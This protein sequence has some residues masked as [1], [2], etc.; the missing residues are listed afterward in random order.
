MK[1]KKKFTVLILFLLLAITAGIQAQDTRWD[2]IPGLI[3]SEIRLNLPELTYIELANVDDVA[4][5][6]KDFKITTTENYVPIVPCGFAYLPDVVLQP[7][8]TFII[9]QVNDLGD[10][11]YSENLYLG[12][13][14]GWMMRTMPEILEYVDLP[15]FMSESNPRDPRDSVSGYPLI[16]RSDKPFLAIA[17]PGRGAF[18]EYFEGGDS[19]F[20]DIFFATALGDALTY[21]PQDG[22][23][24]ESLTAVAGVPRVVGAVYMGGS[25]QWP[26]AREYTLVRKTTVEHG[27]IIWDDERGTSPDNS[28]WIVV[29]AA[30]NQRLAMWEWSKYFTTI[31]RHGNGSISETTVT[32]DVVTIDWVNHK[33]SVPWGIRRFNLM[34]HI[35]VGDNITWDFIQNGN[36]AD[37]AH[38][39]VCTGDKL[40]MYATGEARQEVEFDLEIVAA[41]DQTKALVFQLLVPSQEEGYIAWNNIYEVTHDISGMDTIYGMD[42]G[43]RVDSLYKYLEKAE[44]ATWRLI[45]I[46]GLPDRADLKRG[47]LLRVTNGAVTKDYYLSVSSTPIVALDGYLQF[48]KW[49]D[50]PDAL[51]SSDAW[52]NNDI[53]PNFINVVKDYILDLPSG[54]KDVPA[55]TAIPQDVNATVSIVPA[56]TLNGLPSERTTRITVMSEDGLSTW[57]YTVRFDVANSSSNIQ[58]FAADPIFTRFIPALGINDNLA[59]IGNPGTT[60]IDLSNYVVANALGGETPD[61]VLKRAISNH[62]F[63]FFAYVPG[64]DYA[65]TEAEWLTKPGV[66]HPD[67][68]I[69]PI[70]PPGKCFVMADRADGWW[71]WFYLSGGTRSDMMM[72]PYIDVSFVNIYQKQQIELNPEYFHA[73]NTTFIRAGWDWYGAVSQVR[74]K[75]FQLLYKIVGD[76][77]KEGL[78]GVGSDLAD[79]QLIDMMGTYDNT[80]WEPITGMG[81]GLPV[82]G[83]DW[84]NWSYLPWTIERKP[85][86]WKGNPLPGGSWGTAETSEWTML[87]E[88]DIYGNEEV[89]GFWWAAWQ[90]ALGIDRHIFTPVTESSSTILSRLYKVSG[91]YTSPQTITGVITGTTVADFMANIIKKDAYQALEVLHKGIADA[92][93]SDDTLKVTSKDSKN[94]TNYILTVADVGLSDN[95]TLVAKTGS[96]LTVEVSG[97]DGA[98]SGVSFGI[99]LEELLSNLVKPANSTLR[100]IDESGN[101]VSMK[102]TTAENSYMKVK[103][104]DR[105]R[106]EVIS[107]NSENTI[108]YELVFAGFTENTAY[109]YSNIYDV[110]QDL[111]LV[112]LLPI[113]VKTPVLL[114]NLSTNE[115]ATVILVDKVGSERTAGDVAVDDNLIVTSPDGTVTK[116][117]WLNFMGERQGTDAYITSDVLVVNQFEMTVSGIPRNTALNIFLGLVNPAPFATINVYNAEGTLVTSGNIGE[118]FTL[119]VTSGDNTKTVA[120][121]LSL[122]VT[123]PNTE[124]ELVKIYPNPATDQI[125]IEGLRENCTVTITS[126]LGNKVKVLDS[127][128]IH[129]ATISVEDLPAGIY[130][131]QITAEGYKSQPVRLLVQ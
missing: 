104:S 100:V 6:L 61:G 28:E 43:L 63:R 79:Y 29:P 90:I 21:V 70:L 114:S 40:V 115:G 23:N 9:A 101:L 4:I 2:T 13:E 67:Y 30:N 98:V 72:N 10:L 36:S 25:G 37:S 8:E 127:K 105:I 26:G 39:Y 108:T 47:D 51:R 52:K 68:R 49:P 45:C 54:T 35:T 118:G 11:N 119:N 87:N 109:L 96:G 16:I 38:I 3:I 92:V 44:G 116:V 50:V 19:I 123:V 125:I 18:L 15:V 82:P 22:L 53:I 75:Q 33:M 5:N 85:E 12:E 117:Y 83:K 112:S 110:D 66:I 130:L 103:A 97:N 17:D 59:A 65:E 41:T 93:V 131:I 60:N 31:G 42:Y 24:N 122:L 126:I 62:G 78:K 99:T 84:F 128:N 76:S 111:Q 55:L 7:G 77:I 89:I 120:Y 91:G 34:D 88:M 57:I 86:I 124:I 71:Y 48:I 14:N 1:M 27:N 121:D 64:Y 106:L 129:N 74:D 95:A 94:V 56:T 69:N 20:V 102:Y 80:F 107:E 46:D 113:G 81:P 32:S 73:E 58:P